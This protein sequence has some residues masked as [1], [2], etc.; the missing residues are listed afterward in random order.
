[1]APEAE[2]SE[3]FYIVVG[4]TIH[5]NARPVMDMAAHPDQHSAFFTGSLCS[6]DNEPAEGW[7]RRKELLR[8][9]PRY[10]HVASDFTIGHSRKPQFEGVCLCHASRIHTSRGMCQGK[11][12]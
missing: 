12:S 8:A 6:L 9:L 3:V 11:I 2:K 1:M 5:S 7:G 4:V 10:L